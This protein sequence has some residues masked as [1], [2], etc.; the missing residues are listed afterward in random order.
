MTDSDTVLFTPMQKKKL[1]EM[2]RQRKSNHQKSDKVLD[3][4]LPNRDKLLMR[5]L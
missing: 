3:I 5:Q 2:K 4:Y 1:F